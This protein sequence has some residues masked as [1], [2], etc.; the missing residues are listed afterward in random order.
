[1]LWVRP[2]W[3]MEIALLFVVAFFGTRVEVAVPVTVT[4][5]APVPVLL[6]FTP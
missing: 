4:L 3:L 1:M 2:G 6:A 5:M